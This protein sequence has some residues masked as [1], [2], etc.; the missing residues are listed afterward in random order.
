[1]RKIFR[2]ILV[3]L[4]ACVLF[5]YVRDTLN[6]KAAQKATSAQ[7]KAGEK[8]LKK[9]LKKLYSQ[10]I[11]NCENDLRLLYAYKDIDG[12]GINELFIVEEVAHFPYGD[13]RVQSLDLYSYKN[14]KVKC[15]TKNNNIRFY[16]HDILELEGYSSIAFYDNC[17]YIYYDNGTGD[18][19]Y[20]VCWYKFSGNS[21]KEVLKLVYEEGVGTTFYKGKKEISEKAYNSHANKMNSKECKLSWKVYSESQ[22]GGK[23]DDYTLQNIFV[24]YLKTNGYESW[25]NEHDYYENNM[26]T[27][28]GDSYYV[29]IDS[30]GQNEVIFIYND[31]NV[32]IIVLDYYS[33][34]VH[35]ILKINV[36]NIGNMPKWD[37]DYQALYFENWECKEHRTYN[38]GKNYRTC[39]TF[40]NNTVENKWCV[41]TDWII[42]FDFENDEQT[43]TEREE[44]DTYFI[45][46]KE[47]TAEEFYKSTPDD[48]FYQVLGFDYEDY[49]GY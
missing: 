16:S 17:K 37:Y 35:E 33:G 1:M 9:K 7:K 2:N 10:H 24:N 41:V 12:D 22:A 48:I 45:N 14:K 43:I 26:L 31:L 3:L 47:L 42:G 13:I 38:E 11:K 32:D 46:D 27:E 34:K 30:D 5:V 49:W 29:D 4:I 20:D 28:Y 15:L 44:N 6:V 8:A 19:S 21:Y 39:Y 23:L 40:K 18:D 25:F 36:T